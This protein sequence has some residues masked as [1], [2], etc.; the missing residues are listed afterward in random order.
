MPHLPTPGW[1]A[2]KL[3][4]CGH[5]LALS[6]VGAGIVYESTSLGAA[7]TFY[8]ALADSTDP[9]HELRSVYED[10]GA[11][12]DY[13]LDALAPLLVWAENA[14]PEV[15]ARLRHAAAVMADVELAETVSTAGGDLLGQVRVEL[16]A[17]ETRHRPALDYM[18]VPDAI[19]DLPLFKPGMTM[20]DGWC[21]SGV[22]VMGMAIVMMAAG[23]DVTECTWHLRDP[24][25]LNLAIA[26]VNM[27]ALRLP[28]ITLTCAPG[29]FNGSFSQHAHAVDDRSFE[30]GGGFYVDENRTGAQFVDAM[31]D[32]TMRMEL[33][34]AQEQH[35]RDC[36]LVSD[37][38]E[39]ALYGSPG[40]R[41]ATRQ[42]VRN[43]G[44][45]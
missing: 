14:T 29:I 34:A 15:E 1:L 41:N 7:Q 4:P 23:I 8:T 3:A 45:S 9:L 18:I 20:M 32:A 38:L 11:R 22:R 28:N 16:E 17:I 37:V 36:E 5:A 21:A 30:A 43:L 24:D 13:L 10:L 6:L 19:E 40:V 12:Y 39:E 27:A 31:V 42:A 35:D 33:F 26:A 2:A 25:P 44:L